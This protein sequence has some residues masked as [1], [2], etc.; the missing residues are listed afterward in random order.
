MPQG[1][2][3]SVLRQLPQSLPDPKGWQGD[4]QLDK[5]N[6]PPAF[7]QDDWEIGNLLEP[8]GSKWRVL[9]KFVLIG[10][11]EGGHPEGRGPPRF[12]VQ[13]PP[14]F[15]DPWAG[16]LLFGTL[17]WNSLW[18]AGRFRATNELLA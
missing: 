1:L 18:G 12:S 3:V 11:V 8:R 16:V 10:G 15:L 5:R 9:P 13:P 7:S 17:R 2:G 14:L 4:I 6:A